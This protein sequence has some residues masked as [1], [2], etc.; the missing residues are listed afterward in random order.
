HPAQALQLRRA[1][2]GRRAGPRRTPPMSA[3][4]AAETW[5]GHQTNPV[6][7]ALQWALDRMVSVGYGVVYDYIVE[8]FRPYRELHGDVLRLVETVVPPGASRREIRVLDVACGTGNF[9]LRLASAGF[10]TLGIDAY[11]GLV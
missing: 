1:A 11:A 10:E 3:R 2:G 5:V 7:D 6:L 4:P 9:A 8:R